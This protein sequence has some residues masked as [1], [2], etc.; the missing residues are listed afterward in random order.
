M[1]HMTLEMMMKDLDILKWRKRR[2]TR[3][4]QVEMEWELAWGDKEY[5]EHMTLEMMMK[6]LDIFCVGVTDSL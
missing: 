5:M 6:D 1:E 4:D 3:A 2:V